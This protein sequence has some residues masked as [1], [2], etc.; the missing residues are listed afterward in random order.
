MPR[1]SPDRQ[2]VAVSFLDGGPVNATS[3]PFIGRYPEFSR[4]IADRGSRDAQAFGDLAIGQA[5]IEQ[6]LHLCS[7]V[8]GTVPASPTSGAHVASKTG[9]IPSA[10]GETEYRL[11]FA[12]R[13]ALLAVG[14]NS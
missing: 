12:H 3:E 4:V 10:I 9:P 14:P 2:S 13:M 8:S 7:R 5:L 11:T 1:T 6:R